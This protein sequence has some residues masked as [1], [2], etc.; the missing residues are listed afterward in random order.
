MTAEPHM[1]RVRRALAERRAREDS[2]DPAVIAFPRDGA[3]DLTRALAGATQKTC[4][5]V[6][7][8]VP[9]RWDAGNYVHVAWRQVARSRSVCRV[10]LLPHRGVGFASL[11]EQIALD[12]AAGIE[13]RVLSLPA[14]PSRLSDVASRGFSLI[15][16]SVAVIDG[17]TDGAVGAY[18]TVSAKRDHLIKYE[19]AW[20]EIW[21][22]ADALCETGRLQHAPE[23]EEPLVLSA[24]LVH[25]VAGVLCSGD[26]VDPSGCRWY[27]GAWQYLRLLDL[28]STPSWHSEFYVSALVEQ[29][30]RTSSTPPTVLVCGTADYSVYAYV[31]A[32]AQAAG[33]TAKV[34][35]VDRCPTPLFACQW[36]ARQLGVEVTTVEADIFD[37]VDGMS[38]TFDVVVTDAFLT[39]FPEGLRSAVINAWNAI[40]HDDGVVVT[41]VRIHDANPVGRTEEE[42]I[43]DFCERA[44]LRFRRWVSYVDR[45]PAEIQTLA[46]NYA[47]QMF[48]HTTG[49]ENSIRCQ[50]ETGDAAWNLQFWSRAAVPGE[51]YPTSYARVVARKGASRVE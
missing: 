24:D 25:G 8:F 47:R 33:V 6:L 41:T 29:F 18:L 42:A 40:L 45:S 44:E 26:H 3:V 12:R 7:P 28:V 37:Y 31:V 14:M 27:H 51:L 30:Q 48:S 21:A 20:S 11:V 13:S 9:H 2:R 19:E 5:Q 10:Y 39:R 23:L 50:W 22:I 38:A 4:F 17:G 32:A 43:A 49:S 34:V 16:S 15:D 35:V 1:T 46:Y 36:Y